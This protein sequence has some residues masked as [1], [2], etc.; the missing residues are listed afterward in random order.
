MDF[1]I[2]FLLVRADW[3]RYSV[4]VHWVAALLHAS[5]RPHLA[6]TPLRFANP[7]PPSGWIKDLHLQAAD[8]ARHTANGSRKC[9]PDDKLRAI[10]DI[11]SNNGGL[12]DIAPLMRATAARHTHHRHSPTRNCASF[13]ALLREPGIHNPRRE[14]GFRACPSGRLSP[15]EGA[16]RNDVAKKNRRVTSTHAT[17]QKARPFG[18]GSQIAELAGNAYAAS[19]ATAASSP[20]ASVSASTSTSA[21]ALA[22][23]RGL[24]A[25]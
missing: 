4:L 13:G 16:S 5:F 12:P 3:P 2:D 8:H 25:S 1:A 19:S 24:L 9:A 10:R 15:T 14:Y 17:Q 6:T 20:S 18:P 21:S 7:S 23:R 22:P 11:I